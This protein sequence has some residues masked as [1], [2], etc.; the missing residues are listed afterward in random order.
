MFGRPLEFVRFGCH[1]VG[2]RPSLEVYDYFDCQLFSVRRITSPVKARH[3]IRQ[4]AARPVPPWS[5]EPRYGIEP[6]AA[7]LL[8]RQLPG[9]FTAIFL[10]R[11]VDVVRSS[12][13]PS[14]SKSSTWTETSVE[15]A[16]VENFMS[17]A[18]SVLTVMAQKPGLS[19][20]RV[21]W[22]AWAPARKCVRP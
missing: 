20:A 11:L 5:T 3:P 22:V 12:R 4:S 14:G 10:Q 21:C 6:T 7:L 15:F 13:T 8:D 17:V 9:D 19:Q 16:S 1:G 2:R 18:M